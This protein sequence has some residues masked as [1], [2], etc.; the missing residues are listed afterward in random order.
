M[1]ETDDAITR[2]TD[3]LYATCQPLSRGDVLTHDVIEAVLKFKPHT[4]RWDHIVKKLRNRVRN[5]RGIEM[6]PVLGVGY[7]LLTRD[8]QLEMVPRKRLIR[9]SRQEKRARKAVEALDDKHLT[10][11][12][13]RIK[14][15]QLHS[16]KEA[17][18]AVR[19]Q[20]RVQVAMARKSEVN[21][22]PERVMA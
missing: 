16:L 4:G 13:R 17:G 21:P 3:D 2:A 10:P 18:R 7:K 15:A 11:H 5:R 22:R 1:F 8:E 14:A 20:L 19:Q 6:W 12:Q 9:A